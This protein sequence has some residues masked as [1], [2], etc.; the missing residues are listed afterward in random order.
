MIKRKLLER[1]L[2]YTRKKHDVDNTKDLEHSSFVLWL[3]SEC[4]G[5]AKINQLPPSSKNNYFKSCVNEKSD[6][7]QYILIENNEICDISDNAVTPTDLAPTAAIT[8][9][10]IRECIENEKHDVLE[11]S[12]QLI[13]VAMLR[14]QTNYITSAIALLQIH[15][16]FQGDARF[17]RIILKWI[18]RLFQMNKDNLTSSTIFFDIA[19]KYCIPLKICMLIVSGC[20]M[21]WSRGQILECRKWISSQ[22]TQKLWTNQLSQQLA[23][24]FLALTPEHD[25]DLDESACLVDLCFDS[26]EIE[27]RSE[28]EDL[29]VFRMTYVSPDWLAV[30]MHLVERDLSS[31]NLVFSNMLNRINTKSQ[32][33]MTYSAVVLCLYT[34]YP[35]MA[36]LTE[37]I[38]KTVLINGARDH[39]KAWLNCRCP[40]DSQIK[41]M[42]SN[43]FKSPHKALLQSTMQ[44]F[45]QHPLLLMRHLALIE[46]GLI[47][48]G[49]GLNSDGS[50]LTTRGR[51]QGKSPELI[52]VINEREVKVSILHW[53]YS[54]SEPVWSCALDLLLSIPS[55][56]LFKVGVETGLAEIMSVYSKLFS[57]QANELNAESNISQL[58]A[59]FSRLTSSFMNFNPE[60]CQLIMRN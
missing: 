7:E 17:V 1:I 5:S 52:A 6:G 3:K 12:L 46:Q 50:P 2:S 25:S 43:L 36:T 40:L 20:T 13:E 16:L 31:L 28:H 44:I 53:G 27:E 15:S 45:N 23:L 49:S 42:I 47:A 59:Q 56:I 11:E 51:I 18:P 19:R 8:E 37:T 58:R 48:D 55:E 24:R 38:L 4:T 22:Q 14:N 26:F 9:D 39:S 30:I 57:V 41:A 10:F 21:K 60:K 29:N 34:L 54:F 33:E 32:L 35:F